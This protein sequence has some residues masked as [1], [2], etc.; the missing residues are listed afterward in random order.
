VKQLKPSQMRVRRQVGCE[1][2]H[3][4]LV[5]LVLGG[6]KRQGAHVQRLERRLVAQQAA[7]KREL[8]APHVRFAHGQA[9]RSAQQRLQRVRVKRLAARDGTVDEAWTRRH[10]P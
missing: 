2:H 4:S 1:R 5:P 6:M 10:G 3:C 9:W 7:R 8:S